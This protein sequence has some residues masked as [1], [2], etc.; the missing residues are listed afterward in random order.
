MI[1]FDNGLLVTAEASFSLNIEKDTGN[2]ELLGTKAGSHAFTV[3]SPH[4]MQ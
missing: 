2:V 4:R 3:R 1:R